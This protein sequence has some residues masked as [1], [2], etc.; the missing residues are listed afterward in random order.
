MHVAN[1]NG[2]MP[3]HGVAFPS[4]RRYK[5]WPYDRWGANVDN[6]NADKLGFAGVFRHDGP[7]SDAIQEGLGELVY[8]AD[9]YVG[10]E[11]PLRGHKR[12]IGQSTSCPGANDMLWVPFLRMEEMMVTEERVREIVGEVL[13]SIG[14]PPGSLARIFEAA[15]D[16][17]YPEL[18]GAIKQVH[19]RLVHA[20]DGYTDEDAVA[21]VKNKL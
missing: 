14:R 6:G 17:A 21:A 20:S 4:G 18:F 2:G 13:G 10:A 12:F 16:E 11:R 19:A 3:Y 1:G 15:D 9:D 5:T 8:T 7:P